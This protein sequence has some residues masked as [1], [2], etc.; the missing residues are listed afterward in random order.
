M[1]H[2]AH[3]GM[4][5]VAQSIT[6]PCMRGDVAQGLHHRAALD[7]PIEGPFGIAIDSK[8]VADLSPLAQAVEINAV[9]GDQPC[10]ATPTQNIAIGPSGVTA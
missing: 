3:H 1:W 8:I 9:V 5:A 10:A 4:L 7:H 2:V 6:G